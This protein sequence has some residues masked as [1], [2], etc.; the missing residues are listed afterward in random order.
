M[1]SSFTRAI[2]ARD[3]A[4]DYARDLCSSAECGR[5]THTTRWM[6]KGSRSPCRCQLPTQPHT[7][8]AQQRTCLIL[9]PMRHPLHHSSTRRT[10]LR[11][12]PP[13]LYPTLSHLRYAKIL[14]CS[15]PT[16]T[17]C[18][19][20]QPPVALSTLEVHIQSGPNSATHSSTHCKDQLL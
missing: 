13:S 20:Y 1:P 10:T 15:L 18:V 11:T 17:C 6:R 3:H 5:T 16:S 8:L 4:R 2:S 9:S 7:H 19:R 14:C 12:R